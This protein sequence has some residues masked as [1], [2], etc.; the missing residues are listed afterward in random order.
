M[1]NDYFPYYQQNPETEHL[2]ESEREENDYYFN[3]LENINNNKKRKKDLDVDDWNTKYS[4]DLWYLWSIINEF[5]EVNN[6]NI[7]NKMSYAGFCMM[8][9]DNSTK[10]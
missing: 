10:Q 6:S 3:K 1:N 9:F 2:S 7:L 8:C 4:E 5:T